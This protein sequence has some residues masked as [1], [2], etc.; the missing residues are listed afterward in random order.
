MRIDN[1]M[2]ET[3]SVSI[4]SNDNIYNHKIEMVDSVA[5]YSESA[6]MEISAAGLQLS[7]A[8]ISNTE[9]QQQLSNLGFFSG[10]FDGNLSSEPSKKAIKNF[11]LTYGLTQSGSLDNTTKSKLS[12]A[13]DMYISIITSSGMSTLH[14]DANYSF[15][16]QQ[17]DDFA[18]T[19][20]FLRVGMGISSK[21]AAG[22]M[23]NIYAESAVSHDNAQ[24]NK[25][26]PGKHNP[27]YI[28]DGSDGVGY[29]LI[30]WTA[31]E[32]KNGLAYTASRMGLKVSDINAQLSFLRKELTGEFSSAWKSIESASTVNKACDIFL[33]EIEKPAVPNYSERRT[34]ANK[35]Y[36]YFKN[37]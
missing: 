34:Y 10:A 26:Y 4:F 37:N 27:E 1:K 8:R 30:Q 12:A 15:D 5:D 2:Y 29:G 22:V 9:L 17:I 33:K 7:N 25:S 6:T 32:R 11:Q 13:S 31:K 16:V 36:S 23:G 35:F 28:F 21:A 19:W 18:K 14:K 20:A 24:D 3:N